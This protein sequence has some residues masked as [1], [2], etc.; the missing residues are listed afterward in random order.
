MSYGRIGWP[1][2]ILSRRKQKFRGPYQAA[3]SVSRVGFSPWCAG[4]G[5]SLEALW[6]WTFSTATG[7]H[8]LV[9]DALFFKPPRPPSQSE[10]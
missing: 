6:E 3:P 2:N 1:V 4:R 8:R 9:Y 5:A 7:G 10:H